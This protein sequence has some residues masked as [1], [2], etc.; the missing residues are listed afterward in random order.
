[1]RN[2]VLTWTGRLVVT[3]CWCGIGHAIP[4]ELYDEAQHNHAKTVYCPLGHGWVV[5]GETE[6]QELA[7]Q[8]KRERD[9]LAAVTASRDQIAASLRTTKGV[10]TKMRKRAITG[11]CAFCQRHFTNVERHMAT[12]HPGEIAEGGAA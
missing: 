4:E 9:R 7:R 2:G 5:A 11:T 1:M 12:K 3:T 8:L 10:V 6:A